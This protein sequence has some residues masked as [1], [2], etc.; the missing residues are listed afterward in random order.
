M[1]TK[2]LKAFAMLEEVD[3]L[4][5][6]D[7]Y[8]EFLHRTGGRTGGP[9][10]LTGWLDGV[11]DVLSD[12]DDASVQE[13]ATVFRESAE[14]MRADVAPNVSHVCCVLCGYETSDWA[15]I[16]SWNQYGDH[17][18]ACV[19]YDARC[20]VWSFTDGEVRVIVDAAG[21]ENQ[22]TITEGE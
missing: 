8:V 16:E 15:A 10:D 22:Y 19:T 11:A 5:L 6:T 1:N 20:T 12:R 21:V 7:G 3:R 13:I 17:A 18:G 2:L 14:S 4:T 9:V